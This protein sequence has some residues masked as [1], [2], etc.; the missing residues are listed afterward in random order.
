MVLSSRGRATSLKTNGLR[1]SRWAMP[2]F[3]GRDSKI[4]GTVTAN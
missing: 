1:Y 3:F 4:S 2:R